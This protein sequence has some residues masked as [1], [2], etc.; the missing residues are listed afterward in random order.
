MLWSSSQHQE[1]KLSPPETS[2]E[3]TTFVFLVANGVV[4][5]INPE[6]PMKGGKRV[7]SPGS[8]PASTAMAGA[9]RRARESAQDWSRKQALASCDENL[10][11]AITTCVEG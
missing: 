7:P 9:A 1:K 4:Y 3:A 11:A 5:I 6:S 2:P 10:Y 8:L